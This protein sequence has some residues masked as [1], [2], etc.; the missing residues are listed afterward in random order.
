MIHQIHLL[1]PLPPLL[2]HHLIMLARLQ[3]ILKQM[4]GS[5]PL[6]VPLTPTP[7]SS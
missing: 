4:N 5:N 6:L 2:F 3:N 1:V 7:L